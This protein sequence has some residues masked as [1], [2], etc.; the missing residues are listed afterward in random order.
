MTKKDVLK[1]K[2]VT[3]QTVQTESSKLEQ[4]QAIQEE[5]VLSKHRYLTKKIIT[6]WQTSFFSIQTKCKHNQ[7]YLRKDKKRFKWKVL[8]I[9][10]FK[11]NLKKCSDRLKSKCLKESNKNQYTDT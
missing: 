7:D 10:S 4:T 1:R 8:A 3:V 11:K 9:N 5:S 2:K 6:T